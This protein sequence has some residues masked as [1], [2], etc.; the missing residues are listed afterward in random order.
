MTLRRLLYILGII[1]IFWAIVSGLYVHIEPNNGEFTFDSQY[2]FKI[3]TLLAGFLMVLL[4][5]RKG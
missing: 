1:L 4:G 3:G 5:R 2:T